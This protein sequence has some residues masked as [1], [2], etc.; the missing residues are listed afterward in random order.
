MHSAL[1]HGAALPLNPGAGSN[2]NRTGRGS[3]CNVADFV[4]GFEAGDASS[5][6]LKMNT[7]YETVVYFEMIQVSL[8]FAIKAERQNFPVHRLRG[9]SLRDR[10]RPEVSQAEILWETQRGGGVPLHSL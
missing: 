7:C 9:Q 5:L 6:R 4:D 3:G 1:A 10:K 8:P 2:S